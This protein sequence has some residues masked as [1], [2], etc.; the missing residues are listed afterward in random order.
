VLDCC[1]FGGEGADREGKGAS[2]A[3]SVLQISKATI[4]PSRPPKPRYTF[5]HRIAPLRI[6]LS[7]L[8]CSISQLIYFLPVILGR[9]F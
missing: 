7:M 8:S 2:L 5:L 3:K 9:V 4:F 6:H 1:R